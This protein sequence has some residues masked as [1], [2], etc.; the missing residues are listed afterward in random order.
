M[1]KSILLPL[2]GS[3]SSAS[4]ADTAIALGT[5]FHAHVE[6]LG[7]VNSAYIGRPE[8]VPL[9]AVAYKLAS[10]AHRLSAAA[11]QIGLVL[12][13]FRE[14]AAEAQIAAVAREADGD[15]VTL[16]ER[17]ATPHDMIV[18][19]RESLFS[20]D[21]EL[22]SVPLCV[23][24][25]IR[26]EPRPVLL[27]P[28]SSGPQW[29]GDPRQ[30]VLIGF[31]GSPASSRMLHMLAL[32][33]LVRGRSVHVVTV[34][35]GSSDA[36]QQTAALACLLLNRHGVDRTHAIGLG[37]E[38]AGTPSETILGL[39]RTLE[40]GLVAMGAYGRRGV[41]EIFGSCTREVLNACP[42]PL[43]LHH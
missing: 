39:A 8:P 36:A 21:G 20:V 35:D 37:N 33:G 23:D 43:F 7:I 4:A 32:L 16:I 29:V 17:E 15:P 28:A 9:G 12:R 30:P 26:G 2:D 42:K 13:D 34:A 14:A 27:V 1:L 41:G 38:E 10:D 5:T 40:V 31:D 11:E 25:I 19:G 3:A 18:L 6:A 24:R 22:Y